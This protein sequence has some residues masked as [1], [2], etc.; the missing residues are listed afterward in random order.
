MTTKSEL[1]EASRALM[2][3]DRRRVGEPPTAEEVLAL[4]R[5]EL[6]AEEGA[7]IRERLVAYPDL[8]RT[9]TVPFPTEGAEPGDPDYMSDDEFAAR[10]AA[11]QRR[12]QNPGGGRVL[13]FWR[14][15]GAIAAALALVFGALFWQAKSELTKPRVLWEQ[16]LYPDGRR[17]GGETS[18]EVTADVESFLLVTG[19]SAFEKYRVEIVDA[20]SNVPQTLWKSDPITRRSDGALA[21][22][23]HRKLFQPGKYQLVLYGVSGARQE[24]LSTY[25]IRVPTR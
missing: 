3:E 23:V 24:P 18:T 12:R 7:H 20:A 8:V 6:P 5:G 19:D 1:Y 25:T 10:W 11:L 2:A 21:I 16:E 4:M 13:Q 17:G 9:L 15:F 14:A 22:V